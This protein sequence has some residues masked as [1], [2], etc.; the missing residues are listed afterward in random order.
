[1]QNPEAEEFF[2]NRYA[3]DEV[4]TAFMDS[5]KP[6]GEYEI[7]GDLRIYRAPYAVTRDIVFGGASDMCD[8]YYRLRPGDYEI[9]IAT[10]GA[11]CSL[12]EGWA[13]FTLYRPGWP[14]FD[15]EHWAHR[16]YDFARRG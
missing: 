10:G 3:R 8:V 6:L 1:M 11:A 7:K 9:A 16:A 2:A 5:L 13:K 15:L 12:G 14:K 4:G